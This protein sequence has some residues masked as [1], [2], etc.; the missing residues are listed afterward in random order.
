MKQNPQD[1]WEEK[2]NAT[3]NIRQNKWTNNKGEDRGPSQHNQEGRSNHYTLSSTP[4]R[5][6]K[7]FSG[8]YRMFTKID[9]ILNCKENI[10]NFHKVKYYNFIGIIIRL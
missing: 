2:K 8:T 10:R 9:H 1:M 6:Y 4:N 5:E 7:F 3:L